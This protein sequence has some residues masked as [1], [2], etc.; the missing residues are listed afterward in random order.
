M[1]ANQ[2]ADG[3]IKIFSNLSALGKSLKQISSEISEKY[4]GECPLTARNSRF[5][6]EAPSTPF[7]KTS[8][9]HFVGE[10]E[11]VL[12]KKTRQQVS[13]FEE[14]P[15]KQ[16]KI[17]FICI[18]DLVKFGGFDFTKT[19][20]FGLVPVHAIFFNSNVLAAF[21]QCRLQINLKCSSF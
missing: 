10:V 17:F 4:F 21:I 6:F 7:T 18:T 5:V 8:W 19:A 14:T 15:Y 13:E 1:D 16:K 11:V 3:P 9:K 2:F 12:F 20:H